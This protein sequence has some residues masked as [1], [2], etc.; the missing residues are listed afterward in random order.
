M[1]PIYRKPL[2][3][4]ILTGVF[5]L[6]SAAFAAAEPVDGAAEKLNVILIAIDDMGFNTT[7]PE[8]CTVPEITPNIDRLAKEGTLFTQ[9]Y[10]MTPICGPSRGAILSGRYPH[11]SGMMGHGIQ[12]P[13]NWEEPA[14][15]TPTITNFLKE[16]GYHL[17]AILKQR[18]NQQFNSWDITYNEGPYGIAWGDRSPEAFKERTAHA[19]KSARQEGKP[20]FI[21]ANPIDPHRPWPNDDWEDFELNR[22]NQP[23]KYPDPPRRYTPEEV[24]VPAHLPDLPGV[25]ERLVPYYE[26]LRRGDECVGA[27][28]EALNE[29]GLVENTLVIFLSDHGMGTIGAKG[30]LYHHGLRTPVILRWPNQVPAGRIDAE[31]VISAVDL[32][33]TVVEAIGASQIENLEGRSFLQTALGKQERTERTYAYAAHNYYNNMGKDHPRTTFFPQRAIIDGDYLYIWNSYVLRPGG[34]RPF[35]AKG[36]IDV[37]EQYLTDDYPDLVAKVQR[38]TNKAAEEFFDLRKDPG[39][40]VNRIDDP[41]YADIIDTYRKKLEKEMVETQDPEAVLWPYFDR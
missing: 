21:Y 17:T 11:K 18:R 40:W 3:L 20:F 23:N 2:L 22:W 5:A 32:Y 34:D 28:L 24:Y 16:K 1:K 37:V 30:M 27:I 19:I 41:E 33:P 12:P 6:Q 15:A 9:G 39:C 10:I 13:E 7:S 38:M 35:L 8:G 31:S 26:S 36:W 4:V 25:R 14:D 29:S